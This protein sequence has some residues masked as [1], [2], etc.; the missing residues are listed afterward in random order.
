MAAEF[1][2]GFFTNTPAWHSQGTVLTEAPNIADAIKL[3]GTDWLVE[4]KPL[5]L[6]LGQKFDVD[7]EPRKDDLVVAKNVYTHKALIRST[8][9]RVLGVVGKDYHP[10]QN[11]EAFQWFDFLLDNRDATLEAG[12]SLRNGQRVWVLAK[13]AHKNR[14]VL[15]GDELESY[16]L[17][18]NAH[19]GSMGVWITFTP[20]RVVCMNTLSAALADRDGRAKV[21][22]AISFRHCAN[23]IE[24]MEWAKELVDKSSQ[25]FDNS[26]ETYKAFAKVKMDDAEFGRYFDRVYYGTEAKIN[27]ELEMEETLEKKQTRNQAL[28]KELFQAGMGSDIPGVR[29][30]VWAGY[31]AVT[32]Y[33]DHYRGSEEGVLA[34]SWFGAGAN[35]RAR[36]FAEAEKLLK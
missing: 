31:N 3:S 24:Q 35:I 16:L 7:V 17:L 32:E 6:D 10:V 9:K 34:Q 14:E 26:I 18:S 1:E 2:S 29:G 33:I 5:Y 25:V 23:V 36:A 8:D 22:K 28:A 21:G 20:I 30:T 11:S 19:D 13:M 15:K 4:E 27:V 12:G